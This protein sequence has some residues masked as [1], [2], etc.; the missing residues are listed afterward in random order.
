VDRNPRVPSI[1]V[2]PRSHCFAIGV[3]VN[4]ILEGV[5]QRVLG[6]GFRIDRELGGV[7]MWLASDLALD[8]PVVIKVLSPS[9]RPA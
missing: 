3:R 8:R 2:G 9:A 4:A 7:G 1:R 5:L 6:A